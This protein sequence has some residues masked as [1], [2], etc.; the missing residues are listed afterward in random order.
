MEILKLFILGSLQVF[1]LLSQI[2]R[3]VQCT[4][5][6]LFGTQCL[7]RPLFRQNLLS[8]F[9]FM[10]SLFVPQLSSMSIWHLLVLSQNCSFLQRFWVWV[11][12]SPSFVVFFFGLDPEQEEVGSQ[13]F[14]PPLSNCLQTGF[15]QTPMQ[16]K[17][18]EHRTEKRLTWSK[19]RGSLTWPF[20][21]ILIGAVYGAVNAPT[22]VASTQPILATHFLLP[23]HQTIWRRKQGSAMKKLHGVLFTGPTGSVKTREE[24][25]NPSPMPKRW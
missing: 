10:Q 14:V 15:P 19:D 8:I 18:E 21:A 20:L 23:I 22:T 3:S 2:C 24:L 25:G 6:G 13:V 12:I 4:L 17:L 5:Q 7:V 1:S 9:K 11:V 16:S